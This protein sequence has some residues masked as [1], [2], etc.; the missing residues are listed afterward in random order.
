MTTG[1]VE[2]S[3]RTAVLI[4]SAALE[5]LVAD[6]SSTATDRALVCHLVRL[7]RAWLAGHI[8]PE[9][10]GALVHNN[11]LRVQ[12]PPDAAWYEGTLRA[13]RSLT[14]AAKEYEN[15]MREDESIAYIA[16]LAQEL[17]RR[18]RKETDQGP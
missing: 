9:Q 6:S 18:R 11:V 14:A 16:G 10:F 8:T 4:F 1:T 7:M 5:K 15:A 13:D 17:E 12:L 2:I 3:E